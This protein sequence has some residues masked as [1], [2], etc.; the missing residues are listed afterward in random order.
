MEDKKLEQELN[1]VNQ[2]MKLV[3]A[4]VNNVDSYSV[5]SSLTKAHFQVTKLATTGGFL[6]AGNTTFLMGV[7]ADRVEA[8]IQIIKEN[9]ERRTQV[10]PSAPPFDMGFYT[11]FPL[12]VTVGGATIFVIDV[13]QFRK[14]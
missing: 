1:P 9:S 10:V 6:M 13:E 8:C 5:S 14:V 2:P 11:S 7:A 12:E 3:L 4:I